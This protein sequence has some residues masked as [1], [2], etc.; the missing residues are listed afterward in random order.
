MPEEAVR[1][2]FERI[3]GSEPLIIYNLKSSFCG[4]LGFDPCVENW[5][6][7][8]ANVKNAGGFSN[9]SK[10]AMIIRLQELGWVINQ[11]DVCMNWDFTRLP[12]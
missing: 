8:A 11:T 2:A 5:P 10:Q 7:I 9:V 6:L 3:Y 4:P 1:R 12:N